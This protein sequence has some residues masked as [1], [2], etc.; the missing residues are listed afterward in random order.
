M[1]RGAAVLVLVVALVFTLVV[2]AFAVPANNGLGRMFGEHISTEARAGSL[3]PDLHPGMHLG[4]HGW[5]M[6]TGS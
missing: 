5:P 4:F 6:A 3:G 1:K 2:P